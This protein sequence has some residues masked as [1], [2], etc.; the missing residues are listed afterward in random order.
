[1]AEQAKIAASSGA[2]VARQQLLP[3][4]DFYGS[5]YA[6]GVNFA[7]PLDFGTVSDVRAAELRQQ[8][9]AQL[10]DR[11]KVQE[12]EAEWKD[13]NR[14][15]ADAIARLAVAIDLERLQRKKFES[16]RKRQSA[17]LTVA[18]Q[19]FQYELDYLNAALARVQLQGLILGLRSQ[20]KLYGG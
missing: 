17:G 16:I 7:L 15:F 8:K 10:P 19:V 14:R 12:A 3:T 4:L 6:L 13:L 9:A 1:A 18:F 2:E 5:I 20:L 11:K